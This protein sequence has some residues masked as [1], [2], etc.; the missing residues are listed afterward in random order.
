M[1]E[2]MAEPT[3]LK[4]TL[5]YGYFSRF[6]NYRTTHHI[7]VVVFLFWDSFFVKRKTGL[8]EYD[9]SFGENFKNFHKIRD[10]LFPR[11]KWVGIA[12]IIY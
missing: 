5:L 7:S 11:I 3:L 2:P 10:H 8:E 1:E 6:L 9:D 4:V 12:R